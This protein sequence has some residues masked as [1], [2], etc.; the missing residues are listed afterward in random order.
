M[1]M[2]RIGLLLGLMG[3]FAACGADTGG[4]DAP[5]YVGTE[6]TVTVTAAAGGELEAGAATLSIPP[7]AV[8]ADVEV[9]VAVESKKGKP[10][11]KDILI[12]VYEFGPNMQFAKPVELTFDMK[13][14]NVDDDKGTVQVA[15]LEGDKWNTLPTTVKDGKAVAETTHFTP[16]TL[17]FV[18]NEDGDI[19]Q[20]GG[21]CS[22]DFDACGGDISGTWEFSGACAS[23]PNLFGGGDDG[24]ENPF[25]GCSE[26]P[27]ASI[28]VDINGTVTF[29]KDGAFDVDQTLTMS[30]E[31]A[32][33][34]SCLEELGMGQATPAQLCEG[35]EGT[36]QADKCVLTNAGEGP[37]TQQ[38]METGTYTTEGGILTV[39]TNS[40]DAGVPEEPDMNEYCVKGNELTVRFVDAEEGTEV[41]YTATRK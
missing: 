16:F 15:W 5:S 36:A 10:G 34:N 14:V 38:N 31:A 12:D 21:A 24:E 1:K 26:P 18:L 33:P 29:G 35:L 20:M 11:E 17:V 8:T 32:I 27:M 37:E 40:D 2:L 3:T 6:K 25:A 4:E 7:G 23:V 30:F 39:T 9:S 41:R 22:G 19:V 13:G 28:T